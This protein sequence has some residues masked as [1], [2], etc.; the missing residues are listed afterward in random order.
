MVLV[1]CMPLW[2]IRSGAA[3]SRVEVLALGVVLVMSSRVMLSVLVAMLRMTLVM[4]CVRMKNSTYDKRKLYRLFILWSR[5]ERCCFCRSI[6]PV[7]SS[8]GVI[9]H[10]A[11]RCQ[12]I[13]Y[14]VFSYIFLDSFCRPWSA[15]QSKY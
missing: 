4:V 15:K 14:S 3:D 1:S 10:Q 7:N 8:C 11:L 2:W 13:K 9:C 5:K 6:R 12:L